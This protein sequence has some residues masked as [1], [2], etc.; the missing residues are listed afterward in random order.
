MRKMIVASSS[1]VIG[2]P[3]LEY[4]RPVLAE[5]FKNVKE[6]CF[7]PY[8]RPSGISYDVYTNVASKAFKKIG[9]RVI[10]LH[11][12]ENPSA[13]ILKS[14]AIFTGG[15]NTFELVRQLYQNELFKALK[16]AINLGVPY[17]GTSAGSTICG[18]NMKNTNDMPVVEPPSY[19]TLG[20]FNFNLNTHYFNPE[21]RMVI[22][23]GSKQDKVLKKHMLKGR[24][25]KIKEFHH[26]NDTPVLGLREGSWLE[27]LGERVTLRGEFTARLFR[28]DQ[29]PLELQSE[30]EIVV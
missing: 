10:G 5:H 12:F 23:D 9:I 19:Q 21:D 28:K 4:I 29:N 17:L 13:A 6:L 18:L 7:I 20:C 2:S 22:T 16:K 27:V 30:Q 26:F 3:Y 15:G 1:A 8:A 11:E 14:E 25:T 24:D